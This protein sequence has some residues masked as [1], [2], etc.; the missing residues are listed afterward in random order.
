MNVTLVMCLAL[1][2][3][4]E[5]VPV[6]C[7]ISCYPQPDSPSSRSAMGLVHGWVIIAVGW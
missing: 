1:S 2:A 7:V 6:A 5:F 3:V 4:R